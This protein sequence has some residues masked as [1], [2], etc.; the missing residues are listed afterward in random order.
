MS[1]ITDKLA[2]SVRDLI[3]WLESI[4]LGDA[5]TASIAAAR[6]ALAEYEA[7]Q[8]PATGWPV[9]T[10]IRL[11]DGDEGA[12]VSCIGW[13]DGEF[14]KDATGDYWMVADGMNQRTCVGANEFIVIPTTQ[15]EKQ[16]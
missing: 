7:T 12:L 3:G 13:G 14:A 15:P 5:P 8:E 4:P 10:R 6:T 2:A 16:G 11:D 9:G 1:N